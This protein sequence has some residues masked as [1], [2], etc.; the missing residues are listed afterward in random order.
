MSGSGPAQNAAGTGAYSGQ[1][2]Q[3]SGTGQGGSGVGGGGTSG[4]A[5]A[6]TASPSDLNKIVSSAFSL[7][8]ATLGILGH[9]LEFSFS[10]LCIVIHP[11]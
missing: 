6:A 7:I 10:N 2:Q 1:A 11:S 4:G 3:S 8:L 5:A 9:F